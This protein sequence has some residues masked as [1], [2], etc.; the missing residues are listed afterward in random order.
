MVTHLRVSLTDN[1]WKASKGKRPSFLHR[2]KWGRKKKFYNNYIGC[3]YLRHFSSSLTKG[4]NKLRCFSGISQ[5]SEWA[6]YGAPLGA[7]TLSINDIQHDDTHH[8]DIQHNDTQHNIKV[9][10]TLSIV[11]IKCIVLNVIYVECHLNW[12]SKISP[13]CWVSSCWVS[14]CWV[15]LCWMSWRPPLW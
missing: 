8:S 2:C 1:H 14:L 7:T 10:A 3:W 13:L 15:P 12:V 6:Q 11:T 4:Q 5:P 9:I